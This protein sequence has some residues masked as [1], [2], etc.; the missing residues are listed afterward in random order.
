MSRSPRLSR[1]KA[2]EAV[3]EDTFSMEQLRREREGRPHMPA[4]LVTDLESLDTDLLRKR[5]RSLLRTSAPR[6]LSR[7]LMIRILAWREQI[8]ATGDLDRGTLSVLEAAMEGAGAPSA[9]VATRLRPGVVL[10]REHAGVLHRVA[11]LADGF[12]WNGRIFSSLSA[13]ARA[14]TGVSWNGPRFFGLGRP[15]SKPAGGSKSGSKGKRREDNNLSS[16]AVL[17]LRIDAETSP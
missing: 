12:A 11:V 17:S 7:P 6:S 4:S 3:S 16:S 2:S 9:P 10:V 15:A 13:V 8:A 1:P 5:W 14:I